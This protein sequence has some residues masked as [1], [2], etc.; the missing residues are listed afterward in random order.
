MLKFI[1]SLKSKQL[2]SII[3]PTLIAN[4]YISS[5][6][7]EWFEKIERN[8]TLVQFMKSA[9]IFYFKMSLKLANFS[10]QKII[11][12][13]Y[14]NREL[15][16]NNTIFD[17]FLLS[18]KVIKDGEYSDTYLTGI[19]ELF[20]KR[21]VQYSYLP[22]LY[23]LGLNPLKF[24]LLIKTVRG[25]DKDLIFE[26]QLISYYDIFLIYLK[27]FGYTFQSLQLL[28]SGSTREERL[29][30]YHLIEDIKNQS[31]EPFLR[32]F[33]GKKLAE[34]KN[35]EKI[36]SWSEFQVIER[37]F[38]F[39]YRSNRGSGEIYG[40][41]FY[42]SYPNYFNTFVFDEDYENLSSPHY[43]LVNGKHYLQERKYNF[44][45]LGVSLRYDAVFQFQKDNQKRDE[46]LLLTSYLKKE[47]NEMIEFCKELDLNIKLHPTQKESDFQIPES[48]K[49]IDKNIYH[50]FQTSKIVITTASGT[51][52]EAVATGVSVIIIASQNNLTS[53]PLVDYGQGEIW[54][55]IYTKDELERTL[56]QLLE[57]REKSPQRIEEIA[58]WYKDNFFIE[59]T[60]ENIIKAFDMN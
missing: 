11:F 14:W 58:N 42:L 6:P 60:E 29:F 48:F 20:K 43:V 4:P 36:I 9:L 39:G 27:I 32:Y 5:F 17:T 45:R 41:Q 40:T 53:N 15:K 46:T 38:N 22:R 10:V 50:L 25:E 35:I 18:D 13:I 2:F 33:A 12:S 24:L 34:Y 16:V 47:T 37:A 54:D 23:N 30:N 21:G 1:N 44:Y 49:L 3:N 8:W 56:K 7:K 59:P 52:V 57:F 19:H 55:I 26:H 51:A 28:Q 31:F